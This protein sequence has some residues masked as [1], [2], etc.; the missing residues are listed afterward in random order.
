MR[1]NDWVAFEWKLPLL[2][3]MTNASGLRM[4]SEVIAY[5]GV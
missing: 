5:F 3:R 4:G 2:E 1:L